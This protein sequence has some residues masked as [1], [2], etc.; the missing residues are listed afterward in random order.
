MKIWL[1]LIAALFA[2]PL[3]AAEL[4]ETK[5]Q[6]DFGMFRAPLPDP[7]GRVQS[8]WDFPAPRAVSSEGFGQ[9]I[10]RS[11]KLLSESTL[12]QRNKIRV[13]VYG[14]SLSKQSWAGR[15]RDELGR[16]FPNAQ[17]EF[18]NRSIGGFISSMLRRTL[19]Q[20]VIPLYPDLV[21]LH[22]FGREDDYEEMIRQIRTRTTAEIMVQTDPV[23]PGQ[24]IDWHDEHAVWM[25]ALAK[26]WGLELV[27]IRGAW[28]DYMAD[29]KL[30]VEQLLL[31]DKGHLN[32]LGN[33]VWA[34]T[35]LGHFIAD[36]ANTAVASDAQVQDLLVGTSVKWK[37]NVLRASFVGNRVDLVGLP[38]SRGGS[39][40]VLIDGVAPCLWPQLY[41]VTRPNADPNRDWPW[42]TGTV[43]RVDHQ[44]PQVLEDW[45]IVF[46]K[47]DPS[48]KIYSFDVSGSVTGPDGSGDTAHPFISRSGRVLLSPS[49]WFLSS[50]RGK[51][52]NRIAPGYKIVFSVNGNFSDT[53]VE[54][55]CADES[56]SCVTTIVQG[57][58]AGKHTLELV[59]R[60]AT[61][62]KISAIRIFRPMNDVASP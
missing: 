23:T 60:S 16:R 7:D 59:S 8:K 39:A 17:I 18:H 13:L 36:A 1:V 22:D 57:L 27:D 31:E 45:T 62:P 42:E 29:Q 58:P 12:L 49:D 6:G 54:R 40:T 35:T 28:R 14:Q 4:T 20:D 3:Q 34:Q 43:M 19:E 5:P 15:V 44:S 21:I 26:R 48:G 50:V 47:A 61:N 56:S 24:R 51:R 38:T 46:T 41:Y 9:H 55:G 11:M 52:S 53:F 10:R 2:F 33:F 37:G 32:D 25:K 30:P